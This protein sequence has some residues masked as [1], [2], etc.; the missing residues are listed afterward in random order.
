[1]FPFLNP[2]LP[3]FPDPQNPERMRVPILVALLKLQPH[4]NQSSY[5]NETPSS[6]TSP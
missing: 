2:Y 5:E 1:M 3:E 6:G 4:Y